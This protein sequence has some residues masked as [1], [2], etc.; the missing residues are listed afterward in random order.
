MRWGS[1]CAGAVGALGQ[2]VRFELL[3][4]H[5]YDTLAVEP[6]IDGLMLLMGSRS[7]R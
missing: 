7:A 5:R 2:L 6:L 4:G 3:P 1:W